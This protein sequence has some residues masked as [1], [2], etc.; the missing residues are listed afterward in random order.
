MAG[1]DSMRDAFELAEEFDSCG[2]LFGRP[3]PKTRLKKPCFSLGGGTGEGMAG[4]CLRV[5]TVGDGAGGSGYLGNAGRSRR[6]LAFTNS[7]A[8]RRM[9]GSG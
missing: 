2:V 6:L 4:A 5:A 7:C 1:E 3:P 9:F 8:W